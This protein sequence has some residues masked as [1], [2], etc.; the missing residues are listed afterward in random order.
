MLTLR[1][2]PQYVS[3]YQMVSQNLA[4]KKWKDVRTKG[5]SGSTVAAFYVCMYVYIYI[6]A[7]SGISPEGCSCRSRPSRSIFAGDRVVRLLL[8][9]G[10]GW[11]TLEFWIYTHFRFWIHIIGY[12]KHFL[13][14]VMY[15][16]IYRSSMIITY[17]NHSHYTKHMTMSF[18]ITHCFDYERLKTPWWNLDGPPGPGLG[19]P[20]VPFG[21]QR[22]Q[23]GKSTGN[24][25]FNSYR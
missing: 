10:P 16:Y 9:Q 6:Y 22:W 4:K 11:M 8:R 23:A 14:K 25:G 24:W 12:S 21:H 7:S 5:N 15:I 1:I 3:H 2:F 17:Q 18:Q 13:H 20:Q 19:I